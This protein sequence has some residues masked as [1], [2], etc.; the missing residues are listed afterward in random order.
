MKYAF[1]AWLNSDEEREFVFRSRAGEEE[2]VIAR[3]SEVRELL[4]RWLRQIRRRQG[5]ARPLDPLTGAEIP[6]AEIAIRIRLP[7]W[8]DG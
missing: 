1:R 7:S 6:D 8:L 5:I 3:P 2:I 4:A